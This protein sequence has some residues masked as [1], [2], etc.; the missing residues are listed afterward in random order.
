MVVSV[1]LLV[2]QYNNAVKEPVAFVGDISKTTAGGGSGVTEPLSYAP[3]SGA[4]SLHG[5][6]TPTSSG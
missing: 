4:V 1:A 6:P 3:I 2:V 5:N